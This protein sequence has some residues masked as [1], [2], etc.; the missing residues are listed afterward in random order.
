MT[1]SIL[2]NAKEK[3]LPSQFDRYVSLVLE[4]LRQGAGIAGYNYSYNTRVCVPLF[5][6][7]QRT[8]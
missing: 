3:G 5:V 6:P 4:L 8:A 7:K 2:P 1:C